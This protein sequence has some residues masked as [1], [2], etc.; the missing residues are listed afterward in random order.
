[1][2]K[3]PYEVLGVSRGASQE[4]I[5]K[6]YRKLVQKYHPDKYQGNPLQDLAEEKMREIN[7]AYEALTGG[8]SG[9]SGAGSGYGSGAGYGAGSGYGTGG[10]YGQGYSGF[11]GGGPLNEI[12]A[13]I[14][15]GDLQTAERLLAAESDHT[16]EW[17]FL[18]G[19]VAYE[20]GRTSEGMREVRQAMDMDPNNKEYQ[21]VYAQMNGAGS[22]YG[23]R[24]DMQGYGGGQDFPMCYA[25]PCFFPFCC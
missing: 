13:A 2:S 5:K 11:S 17:M 10:Y 6:A 8:H 16:A 4:E 9:G 1:M 22:F 25:L 21:Q 7:E 15:R 24:S 3:D 12:R 18:N 23:G 20:R 14:M 19:V